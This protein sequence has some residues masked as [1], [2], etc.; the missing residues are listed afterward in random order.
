MHFLHPSGIGF[1][2][3]CSSFPSASHLLK[4]AGVALWF[5]VVTVC[6]G[7][8]RAAQRQQRCSHLFVSRMP[9]NLEN[10]QL[11]V[12]ILFSVLPLH[13]GGGVS[14]G[15]KSDVSRCL[16]PLWVAEVLNSW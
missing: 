1:D 15:C 9:N 14:Q 13:N 10:Y 7:F 2:S 16:L 12:L 6:P 8:P 5:S 4:G 11:V 3:F